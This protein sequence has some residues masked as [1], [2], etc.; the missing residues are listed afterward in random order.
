[1]NEHTKQPDIVERLNAAYIREAIAEI[2]QLKAEIERLRSPAP[3]V[4]GACGQPWTGEKCGQA[5]NSH[6]F[7]VCYPFVSL[8][9]AAPWQLPI[10]I[11]CQNERPFDYRFSRAAAFERA[12]E[13]RK[14]TPSGNWSV[15]E[16]EG[17]LSLRSSLAPAEAP[18]SPYVRFDGKEW[19][20]IRGREPAPPDDGDGLREALEPFAKAARIL[21]DDN[22]PALCVE[23]DASIERA[24]YENDQPTVG[25][26]RRARAALLSRVVRAVA[27]LPD[28]TSPEDQP[29]M[30][31]VAG[32]EFEDILRAALSSGREAESEGLREAE[33][34]AWDVAARELDKFDAGEQTYGHHAAEEVAKA[35]RALSS[36]RD[37]KKA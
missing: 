27:E 21:D 14:S 35:I 30:M 13:L 22:P 34:I 28:R 36:G 2:A 19:V 6:P 10:W 5:D 9:P 16:R 32:E 15:E 25:D 29:R 8:A 24:L 1:M 31:L 26:L 3:A 4:C 37:G 23:D 20:P 33:Q 12:K 7:P 11:I 18:K 17:Y